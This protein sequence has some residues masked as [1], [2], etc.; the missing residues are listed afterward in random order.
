MPSKK[1]AEVVAEE[2]Q[3]DPGV[4]VEA[5]ATDEHRLGLKPVVRS[6]WAPVGVRPVA[7]GHHR[8]EWL[9]ATVFDPPA[10]GERFWYISNGVSKP[11]FEALLATFAEEAG[12]G[13]E[14]RIVLVLDNTGWHGETNLKVPDGVRLLFLPRHTPE[15]QPAEHLW[16]VVDDPIINKHISDLETLDAI[17]SERCAGLASDRQNRKGCTGFHWRSNIANAC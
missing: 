11:F 9:Y 10:A 14:R 15:L 16:E 13:R 8:F 12:A 17:V 1:V 7:H 4:P 3:A 6:V 2:A 5:F